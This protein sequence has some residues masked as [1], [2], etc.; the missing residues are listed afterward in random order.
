MHTM[1][2]QTG[3]SQAPAKLRARKPAQ[4]SAPRA[5][6]ERPAL[7]IR[8]SAHDC[9]SEYARAVQA[10]EIL[11]GPHVRAAGARHLRDLEHGG[12]RG[13]VFDLDKA[14]YYISFIENFLRLN[15][16][17]FEGAPFVLQPWQRFIVGSLYGWLRA[18]T[19]MRRFETAYIEVAK[20][21]GKSPLAAAVGLAGLVIDQEPRAEIYAAATKKD[22]A[23]ILFR[24]AV[25]MVM[26]S[27]DLVGRIKP[28]GSDEKVWNLSYPPLG[29]FFRPISS[30]DSQSGPRPHVALVD[31]LHEHKSPVVLDMLRR[32][33]K[34]RRQPLIFEIT[35]SGSDRNSICYLHHQASIKVL[36][37]APGEQGFDDTW[38]SYICALDVGDDWMRDPSCWAKAN[39][40]LGISTPVE[41]LEKTVIEARNIPSKQNLIARLHFCQWTDA[42]QSWIGSEP[43][44]KAEVPANPEVFR[45]ARVYAGLDLSRRRDLTAMAWFRPDEHGGGDACVEF[46]TPGE[47]LAARA[48]ADGV[49][50]LL[51]RDQGHLHAVP[52]Q[53]VDYNVVC[54]D[55]AR[56]VAEMDMDVA[57]TA[58]DRYRIDEFRGAMDQAGLDLPLT[59][60]G[61]GFKDMAP[62]VERLENMLLNGRLRVHSNPVLRWNAASVVTE[63]DAAGNRKFTKRRSTGRIDGIVALVMAVG[64]A[65]MPEP[66]KTRVIK[67]GFVIV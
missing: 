42:E 36:A 21:N 15:G 65:V 67:Q 44:L 41:R 20:G 5:T 7:A 54:R 10:G 4:R 50:Y 13:L 48:D 17:E 46:W 38:F 40:N 18:G 32:G 61:Q 22:Q 24:D 39:P 28:S 11:A 9:V 45:G 60:F 53:S 64:V 59:Q 27:P 2:A 6:G 37:A 66:E 31:E 26:Q 35:N 58:Y 63:E 33:L 47:T 16:G 14:A 12:E 57:T 43:W 29:S 49:P 3:D 55:I 51:W 25:A 8:G 1:P 34:G 19:G 62:A 56:R 23:M 52:G 30:D